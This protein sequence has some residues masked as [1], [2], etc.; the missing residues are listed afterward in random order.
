MT[1]KRGLLI[2]RAKQIYHLIYSVRARTVLIADR[3]GG[4]MS[5][6]FRNP[7][8][9]DVI[10]QSDA[11]AHWAFSEEYDTVGRDDRVA[12]LGRRS[13]KFRHLK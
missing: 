10:N 7:T 5:H 2:H 8:W 9:R 11:L 3:E 4:V 12:S 1:L 13:W 6:V